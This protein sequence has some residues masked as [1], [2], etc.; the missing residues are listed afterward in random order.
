MERISVKIL[1]HVLCIT[2]LGC[3]Y[4]V[5]L[6]IVVKRAALLVVPFDTGVDK[7]RKLSVCNKYE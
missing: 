1:F 4:A 7:A 2:F 3:Q 6:C 5:F